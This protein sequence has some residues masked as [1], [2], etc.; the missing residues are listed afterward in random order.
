LECCFCYRTGANFSFATAE[1][2]KDAE[3]RILMKF[4]VQ[5]LACVVDW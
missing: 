1:E 5:A 2:V 4:R 3:S